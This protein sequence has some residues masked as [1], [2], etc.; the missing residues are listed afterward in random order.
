MFDEM[1]ESDGQLIDVIFWVRGL[2]QLSLN[3]TFSQP[4]NWLI[5]IWLD[6]SFQRSHEVEMSEHQQ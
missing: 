5:N 1:F 6:W 3:S 2:L 4:Y